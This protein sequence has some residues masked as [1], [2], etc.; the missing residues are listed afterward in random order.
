MEV[1]DGF[2]STS[3]DEYP[4]N[5]TRF[6]EAAA[7]NVPDRE[8]VSGTGEDQFRYTYGEAYER[9]QRLANALEELGVEAGDRVGVLAWN[10]HRHYECY[11]GIPG[12]GAVFL[13]L[14]LRLHSDQLQYV[15]NHSE[16][17]F[18]VVDE[19]LLE[20]AEGVAHEVSSIEGFVVMTDNEL[21]EVETDLEPTYSYEDILT[22]AEPEYD[23][24]YIDETSAYSACYTTG[25]TGRPKGVYYSHRSIYLHT[26]QLANSIGISH[27]DSVAQITPM[28]HGQGWGLAYAATYAGAKLAFPGR[29]R[30]EN[31]EP[32]VDLIRDEDATVTNGAPAIFMPMLDYIRDLDDIPNWNDLQ[33]MSGATE[34]PLDMIRGYKELTGAEIVHAYGATETTP[35][36]TMNYIKPS[37]EEDLSEEEKLDMRR[38]QGLTVPGIEMK[39][40]DPTTG[41]ELSH[42]GESAGEILIRGP[43]VVSSYHDDDRTEHSFTD[44]GFWKSGDAGV[45][46]KEGYLK[47]TDRIKDVIK[48]GGEWISSVDMENLLIEHPDVRDACVVGLE[49][50]EWEERPFALVEVEDEFD[51][52]ELDEILS[53]RFA[54]WQLPDEIE[55]T[56]EIPKTSVGKN[57]KKVIR[58][59]YE[60]RYFD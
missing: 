8:I 2:P 17:R 10:D 18:L 22:E 3:G 26:M 11:F 7:R 27:E 38:K 25:T 50:P 32:L 23:W 44:D 59:Q 48:S 42:D 14:N 4:L 43:W 52:E 35:L 53:Q 21:D 1:I 12:T 29:Y 55:F 20:V 39:I 46:D 41:E 51:R 49:H 5:T 13:Q 60:G 15:L 6:I 40:V 33:M 30:A 24:P 28:F 45:I 57:N 36:V 19:S 16:P 9:M 31:P 56:N 54:D 47:I 58:N 37:L 34:P